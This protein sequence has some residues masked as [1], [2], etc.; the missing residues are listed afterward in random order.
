MKSQ[1]IA[2]SIVMAV[3]I[4]AFARGES[5]EYTR[6]EDVIYGRKFGTALTM[7]VFRPKSGANGAA[8]VWVVSGA[9]FS[10]HEHISA[11]FGGGG[12]TMFAVVHGSQPRF[13]IVDAVADLNRAVRYIRFHAKDY[14]IDPDRI[15]ITGGSAGGHLSLMQGMKPADPDEKN[16]DPVERI[17]A[18]VQAVACLF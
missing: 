8:I 1:S 15:G 13:T 14:G 9:W 7:D 4:A 16:P 3:C 18:R 12:Y 10:S 11:K 17:S 6:T 5:P 2:L